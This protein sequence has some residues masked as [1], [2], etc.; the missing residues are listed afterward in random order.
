MTEELRELGR[1]WANSVMS[2]TTL[3]PGKETNGFYT[4]IRA[5]IASQAELAQCDFEDL[6]SDNENFSNLSDKLKEDFTFY[7]FSLYEHIR[8]YVTFLNSEE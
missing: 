1:T 6:F 2:S 3:H 4:F 8:G 5:A 7:L